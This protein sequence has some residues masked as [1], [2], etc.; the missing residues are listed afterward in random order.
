V[1]FD[2]RIYGIYRGVVL[3]CGP[4]SVVDIRYHI[5]FADFDELDG[6]GAHG[7]AIMFGTSR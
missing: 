3:M 7:L 6:N 2:E 4:V 1:S 5:V